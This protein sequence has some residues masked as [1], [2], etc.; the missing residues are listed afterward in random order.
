MQLLQLGKDLWTWEDLWI[1]WTRFFVKLTLDEALKFLDKKDEE[2]NNEAERFTNDC[3]KLK[4]HR[5]TYFHK[6]YYNFDWL[7]LT[8]VVEF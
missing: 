3:A 7:L 8:V 2:L 4:V 6:V 1:H 5:R